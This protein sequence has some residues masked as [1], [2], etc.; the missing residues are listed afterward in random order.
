MRI[1]FWCDALWPGMGGIPVLAADLIT[2]LTK[3]GHEL[4]V[5]T[6][7]VP[8]SSPLPDPGT[9]VPIHRYPF[10]EVLHSKSAPQIL[11]LARSISDFKHNLRP[12][13]VLAFVLTPSLFFHLQTRRA[14]PSPLMVALHGSLPVGAES[15][16]SVV[17]Q[18]L[19]AAD[20]VT[21][22][23]ESCWREAV[24]RY[25]FISGKSSVVRNA[26]ERRFPTPSRLSF[27]PPRLLYVGRLSHE[28]GVDIAIAALP[29]VLERAPDA[30][31]QVAG[32][33]PLRTV[34][35][36]LAKKFGLADRVEFFGFV[37]NHEVRRLLSEASIVAVPSRSEGF[38]L[39]A[40]E[41]AQAGRPVVASRLGGLPEV[42]VDGATGL[43]VPPESPPALAA[44]ILKLIADPAGAQVMAANACRRAD[45][46][47]QWSE[48]VDAYHERIMALGRNG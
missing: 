37:S 40:L 3:R 20:W 8:R 38:S 32:D 11:S 35:R 29:A 45:E 9:A 46:T 17:G 1:L 13:L 39:V 36:D 15:G 19:D 26:L 31:L 6:D 42:V 22:C 24:G 10:L 41:A 21:M 28:K 23:S 5:V 48:Y 12:D 25:P 7:Q 43:L 33:G 18:V 14:R 2:A 47:F 27:D 16:E 44:A 30:R 34:L 4:H